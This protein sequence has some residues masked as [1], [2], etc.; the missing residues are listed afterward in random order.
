[1]STPPVTD[2]ASSRQGRHDE[3]AP[4]SVVPVGGVTVSPKALRVQYPRN[5]SST[6]RRPTPPESWPPQLSRGCSRTTTL[7]TAAGRSGDSAAVNAHQD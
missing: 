4:D 1:M 2:R 7:T 5:W 3:S 6:P